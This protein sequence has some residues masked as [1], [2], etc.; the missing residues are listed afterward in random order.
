MEFILATGN[1]HKAAELEAILG[2]VRIITMREAGFTGEIEENGATFAENAMIKCRAVW[3]YAHKPCL[4]DDSGLCVDA[5]N[6]APGIHSARYAGEGGTAEMRNA[7][8]L[9]ALKDVPEERRGAHFTCVMAC[10]LDENTCF[11]VEGRCEGRIAF[12]PRGTNGFGFDPL[13]WLPVYGRT[14]AE[15]PP[16]EKNRI[17]HRAD[18][19]ARLREALAGYTR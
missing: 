19:C 10:I 16:E 3:E 6:G 2:G 8:L 7:K 5:L 17:S 18:A 13:F 15:L 14:L 12:E 11:T 9:R 4:A 1:A